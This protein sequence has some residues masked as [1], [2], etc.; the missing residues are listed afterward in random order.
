MERLICTKLIWLLKISQLDVKSTFLHDRLNQDILEV[1]QRGNI[2]HKENNDEVIMFT[3]KNSMLKKFDMS[4]LGNMRKYTLEV[5]RRFDSVIFSS[6]KISK[7]GSERFLVS[8]LKHLID[9]RLGVMNKKKRWCITSLT[10]TKAGSDFIG[11]KEMRHEKG[12][13]NRGYITH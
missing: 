8:N 7:D 3:F 11:A 6:F 13:Y 5:L 1:Q 9:I 10:L 12:V 2:I 4:N